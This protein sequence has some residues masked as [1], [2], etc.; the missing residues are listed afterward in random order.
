MLIP[1]QEITV[2]CAAENQFQKYLTLFPYLLASGV[3]ELVIPD[4]N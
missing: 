2:I 4:F 3:L 1:R